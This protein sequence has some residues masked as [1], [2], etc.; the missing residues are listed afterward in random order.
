VPERQKHLSGR[1]E[2]QPEVRDPH[3]FVRG[4]H[5][6]GRD[7]ESGHDRRDPEPLEDRHDRQRA[8]AS[9]D[10]RTDAGRQLDRLGREPDRRRVRRREA[11]IAGRDLLD[12]H[13][14]ARREVAG[15]LRAHERQ[16]LRDRLA[17]REAHRQVRARRRGDDR[18]LQDG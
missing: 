12:L 7:V 1:R 16:Q 3:P 18:P 6:P 5:V 13:V 15:Q 14:R 4:M 9:Q 10:E 8:A 17:G 2:R 11:G